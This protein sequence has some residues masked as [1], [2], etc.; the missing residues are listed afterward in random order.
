[1]GR[2]AILKVDIVGDN[3]NLGRSVDDSNRK[4]GGLGSGAKK[5]GL[6]AAAGLAVAGTA[7]IAM[8]KAV[9]GAA[10]DLQQSTGAVEQV[11]G[12]FAGDIK[13]NAAAAADAVGLSASAY[14]EMASIL[15]SQLNNMGRS[16]RE[17]AKETDRLIGLGSDLAATYGG[18]VADAV[19]AVSS[20][21]KGETDPIERYGVSIKQSDISARLA[22]DGLDELTGKAAKQAQATAVL[23]LLTEQTTAAHGQFA[24]QTGT[25]AEQQQILSAKFENVKAKIGGA[26]LPILAKLASWVSDKVFPAFG[27]FQSVL[28]GDAGPTSGVLGAV[29]AVATFIRDRLIPGAQALYHWFREKLA[30]GIAQYVAPIIESLRGAFRKMGDAVERN[31]PQLEE[32]FGAAKKLAEFFAQRV[33]PILGKLVGFMYGRF[34]DSIIFAVDIIAALVEAVQVLVDALQKLADIWGKTKDIA[35]DF[36]GLPRK[37]RFG[38]PPLAIG[39]PGVTG[40]GGSLGPNLGS[41][42]TASITHGA[43][44][45]APGRS[46]GGG[47]LSVPVVDQREVHFH[48]DGALDPLSVARQV[49]RLLDADDVR[50]GRASAWGS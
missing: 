34:A 45:V 50:M 29:T 5:A 48:I 8:G 49:R 19:A 36:A 35:G 39:A 7:A 17:S 47:S 12:K 24:A 33:L 42:A 37:L 30:P 27:L 28:R 46:S 38:G 32:L 22:A 2:P 3:R 13:R 6:V 9:V 4:L 41:L 1:M 44:R 16:Q 20:L 18:S 43:Y 23:K 31:R 26:L 10:S 14:Q 40:G 25:L 15:G 11:F 21:M